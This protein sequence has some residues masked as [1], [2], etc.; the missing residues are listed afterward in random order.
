MLDRFKEQRPI[1]VFAASDKD[2]TFYVWKDGNYGA[3]DYNR[4]VAWYIRRHC[5]VMEIH[6]ELPPNCDI[7]NVRPLTKE[8][9]EK[10]NDD[11][12]DY[13]IASYLA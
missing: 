11:S 2:D 6:F 10:L 5:E 8:E 3:K 9:Y 7:P 12:M 1:Y 4:L 13:I